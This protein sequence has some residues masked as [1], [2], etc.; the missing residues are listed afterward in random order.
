VFAYYVDFLR[1]CPDVMA[2]RAPTVTGQWQSTG[3]SYDT[4]ALE[5]SC[6]PA[7]LL[8]QVID[9]TVEFAPSAL[10]R[11]VEKAKKAKEKQDKHNSSN[12]ESDEAGHAFDDEEAEE[13][14]STAAKAQTKKRLPPLQPAFNSLVDEIKQHIEDQNVDRLKSSVAVLGEIAKFVKITKEKSFDESTLSS[15]T[16][17]YIRN[18]HDSAKKG[19]NQKDVV[20]KSDQSSSTSNSED[21]EMEQVD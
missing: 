18:A 3:V 4:F 9:G 8:R 17:E 10:Q 6:K 16:E 5:Q 13:A 19:T 1:E 20:L 12:E 15:V 11:A 2:V 14:T 21:E 7:T